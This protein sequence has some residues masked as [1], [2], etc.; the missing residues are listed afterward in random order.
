MREPPRERNS[1]PEKKRGNFLFYLVAFLILVF[2]FLSLTGLFGGVLQGWFG[3]VF[4]F[5]GFA[6]FALAI[7]FFLAKVLHIRHKRLK[8]RTLVYVAVLALICLLFIHTFT[9]YKVVYAKL[10][11]PSYGKYLKNTYS[12]GLK[13]SGGVLFSLL[14]YPMISWMDK[15]AVIPLAILFFVV[16]FFA[17]L[18]FMRAESN[19]EAAR[20]TRDGRKN[21]KEKLAKG[22][23]TAPATTEQNAPLRMFVDKVTP[24]QK[25]AQKIKLKGRFG[26]KKTEPMYFDYRDTRPFAAAEGVIPAEKPERYDLYADRGGRNNAAEYD[27]WDEYPVRPQSDISYAERRAAQEMLYPE[28]TSEQDDLPPF[29]KRFANERANE[30]AQANR[31]LYGEEDMSDI[32]PEEPKYGAEDSDVSSKTDPIVKQT[33]NPS[34]FSNARPKARLDDIIQDMSDLNRIREQE[35]NAPSRA[36]FIGESPA[37]PVEKQ[38]VKRDYSLPSSITDTNSKEEIV[39]KRDVTEPEVKPAAPLFPEETPQEDMPAESTITPRESSFMKPKEE[40]RAPEPTEPRHLTVEAPRPVVS[41]PTVETPGV[42]PKPLFEEE[43]GQGRT[44]KPR[45]DIGGTHHTQSTEKPTDSYIPP[46]KA[47]QIDLAEAMKTEEEAPA[48]P[49]TPP[50][51]DLLADIKS[52]Q[53]ESDVEE[54]A[55]M[56]VQALASFNITS[57]VIDHK[58]G[59]T[60]TRFAVTLPDNMSVNKLTPLEKDIK[61]KLKVDK[62]I[63]IISSVPGLDAVGVEVPNKKTSMVGLRSIISAPEF[64]KEGKLYFAIGVDVSGK[65][66]YG[67]L[68]KMPH[69]LVAGSTG[70]GKSVCLNVMICSIMYHYSPEIVRFIMVDPKKVELSVYKNMPHMLMP[71]TVTESDK[72][73]NALN[74]AVN[75][76]E[77]RYLLLMENGCRNIGEYNAIQAKTGGKKLYYIVIIIDEMADLMY[78]AKRDVEEKVNRITA[79]ARAAGIHLVVATQRPSVD[80]ITGTIKNNI[81]S[82]IAFKVTSFTDSKTI[83]DKAGAEALFGNG[84]ML[85]MGPE[86]GDPQRLQGPYINDEISEI[87]SFIKEH[88]DCR[89]DG[90]AERIIQSDKQEEVEVK[91]AGNGEKEEVDDEYFSSALLYFI[92]QGQASISQCQYKFRIGYGRAMRI[93]NTMS[94]R[95]YLGPSEGGNKPRSVLITMDQYYELYGEDGIDGA[96][97]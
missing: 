57:E 72:A 68:L 96:E 64:S 53:D 90:E 88:N 8:A 73:I 26:K 16:L 48:R 17:L 43:E 76:M 15:F 31:R 70:S 7:V 24:G 79:K 78:A 74:W 18:P 59:P 42:A 46:K 85:Y 63:R 20:P 86:G 19:K 77:R 75:E 38:P 95:G 89:F 91:D 23:K 35:K 2:S 65:A 22:K 32:L 67:D 52:V 4:G 82:R 1:R 80:V 45:S 25:D 93:V 60:F 69:L 11:S 6:Y 3:G 54:R 50:P 13:T 27:E 94:E 29:M 37:A 56:L 44:R 40:V 58:T 30:K 87:V 81:P 5:L 21:G 39:Q 49:Y 10:A 92:Q 12:V 41:K 14:T 34:G 62:N 84:D 55:E 33:P 83:L 66:V 9:S 97:V 61:R 36:P 71:S 51:V 47:T 28:Q